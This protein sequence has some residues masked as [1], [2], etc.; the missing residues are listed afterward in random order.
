MRKIWFIICLFIAVLQAETL[1]EVNDSSN[2]PVLNVSTDGL[3]VLNEGDTLMVISAD[4]IRAN[5]GVTSKGLSRAFSV[6]TTQSKGKGLYNALE[7]N[8]G[9]TTMSATEGEYTNFSPENIFLGLNAGINTLPVNETS[10]ENNVFLGNQ[11]GISNTSGASNVFVGYRAG[12]SNYT[13]YKNC[14]IGQESG[15]KNYNG[16]NN[17]FMGYH[18]GYNN[19]DGDYNVFLGYYA[20]NQN[21]SGSRNVFIGYEA[22]VGNGSGWGNTFVGEAS[23]TANTTGFA[24][25]A[26]GRN[27]GYSNSEGDYNTNVG[28]ESNASNQTGN[29]NSCFGAESGRWNYSSGSSNSL[30]GYRAGY[31]VAVSSNT[32]SNNSY[33]GTQSGFTTTTGSNNSYFGYQSGYSNNTGTGNV[34]VGYQT[35]YNET[36]S[37]KLYIDN[38]STSYPLIYGDFDADYLKVNGDFDVR[39]LATVGGLDVN[40]NTVVD[41]T[42]K[43]GTG[44]TITRFSTDGTMASNSDSYVPTEKAV[45]TYVSSYVSSNGDNLG[46]HTASQNIRLNGFYLSSDGGNEGVYVDTG[47]DVGIGTNLPGSNRLKV[48]NSASGTT[49]ATGWFENT[50]SLGIGLAVYTTS[51]DAAM[52]VEQKHTS[53]GNIAKFASRYGGVWHES[54]I[55]KNS[56]GIVANNLSS[57]S[58]TALVITT[59]NEIVK[60]SSSKKYKRDIVSLSVDKEKFMKL[61]P[62]DFV[63]NEKSA[64]EGKKDKGL[65]AEEVEKIDPELAV[66]DDSGNIEGVDYQKINIMLLKVVQEQ[67]KKI[68]DLE[69][70]MEKLEK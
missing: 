67:Q 57:G 54:V 31:G 1:F 47:G 34:F 24:N 29:Y 10:G 66:Y 39:D 30:F 51:T 22:G 49:G 37:N 69:R 11:S 43:V 17:V 2:N 36:G 45:R 35:G 70:R 63:W 8:S 64:S 32:Y 48:T 52:Y 13:G 65:I 53:G 41:G 59:G 46:Y 16:H 62:V 6:T 56:G 15:F 44:G 28:Y 3:R 40:G 12:N 58:G 20:G 19:Y 61:R 55:F 7:V 60:Y 38:S 5:I 4:A 33:F 25:S 27:A 18:S 42:F 9:S 21:S 23:A 68:E 50:N 14:F 26:F